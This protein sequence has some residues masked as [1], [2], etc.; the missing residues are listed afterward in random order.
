MVTAHRRPRGVLEQVGPAVLADRPHGLA[1][2]GEGRRL[3]PEHPFVPGRAAEI[4]AT[5]TPAKPS[6]TSMPVRLLGSSEVIDGA[7]WHGEVVS[8][9]GAGVA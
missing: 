2:V 7:G 4:C 6:V 5:R 9:A 3:A 1:V 8:S